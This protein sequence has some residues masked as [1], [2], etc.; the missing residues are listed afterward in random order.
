MKSKTQTLLTIMNVLSWITFLGLMVKAGAILFSYI[1]ST[2]NPAGSKNLYNGWNLSRIREYDFWHYT[3]VVLLMVMVII[4][5]SYTAYLVIKLLSS[6]KLKNPFTKEV[7]NYLERISYFIFAI[8]IA[9][10]LYD[11]HI[12]WLMKKIGGLQENLISGEFIFLAG[13]IFVFAQ[14]FKKGV[15][16]QSEHELT[17]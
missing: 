5:E 4:I 12:E 10:M 11:I 3:S 9:V 16:I 14:I 15:E 2:I 1:I 6:I 13:V 17:V 7:A 8:W